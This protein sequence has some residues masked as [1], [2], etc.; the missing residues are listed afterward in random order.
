MNVNGMRTSI[1]QAHFKSEI[2]DKKINNDAA[3]KMAKLQEASSSVKQE[4]SLS[5]TS[6]LTTSTS[7]KPQRP[8][9]Y[10][11][12]NLRNA[13]T[14]ANV[15]ANW[16][17]T[18]TTTTSTTASR[19]TRPRPKLEKRETVK[20]PDVNWNSNVAKAKTNTFIK[21]LGDYNQL[22][23]QLSAK[24]VS[25][26]VCLQSSLT[27]TNT[28]TFDA[29]VN[30]ISEQKD[31]DI[32][33]QDLKTQADNIK[34]AIFKAAKS[35]NPQALNPEFIKLLDIFD[36]LA[37]HLEILAVKDSFGALSDGDKNNIKDELK[38]LQNQAFTIQ[39]EV[40]K[41]PVAQPS[42]T[43]LNIACIMIKTSAMKLQSSIDENS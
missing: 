32:L 9:F 3:S 6:S 22:D 42:F 24:E 31:I 40:K 5:K 23:S 12:R 37:K 1:D 35:E 29:G 8:F 41:L 36:K 21:Q 43:D 26:S 34:L 27:S 2:A 16:D 7:T 19:Q 15:T 14:L 13:S 38:V 18:T 10:A 11:N 28:R 20:Q 17:Q 25:R 33:K 39:G 30:K 4:I